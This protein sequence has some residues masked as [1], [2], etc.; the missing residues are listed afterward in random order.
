LQADKDALAALKNIPGYTPA[1]AGYTLT[2]VQTAFDGM[3][4]GQ[5]T[6]TQ[7]F[8]EADAARDDATA[9]E[10]AFHKAI[11]G[12]KEQVRAQYG[13]DSNELQAI[14]LTKKLE[15]AKPTASVKPAATT[16]KP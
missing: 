15:K 7:K 11:L 14:G 6:E 2:K 12:V 5:Q 8:A 3:D 10:W 16:P 4:A 13:A 1:N 9:A